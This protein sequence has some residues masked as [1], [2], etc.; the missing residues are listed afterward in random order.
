MTDKETLIRQYAAGDLTWHALQERGFNDYIQVLAALGE[1]GLR[2]PI[3]PMTGP[4][5]AARERGRAMIRDA[6]RARP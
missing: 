3:A 5:R 2:P 4:N 1:L 6:L